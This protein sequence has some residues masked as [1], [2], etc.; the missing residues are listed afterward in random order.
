MQRYGI[1]INY[2]FCC[3]CHTCEVACQVEHGY[4]PKQW[5]IKVEQVGP[6]QIDGTKKVIYDCMPVMT[7]L[8]DMCKE[9]TEKGKLPTCAHH[10]QTGCMTYGPIEELVQKINGNYKWA[11]LSPYVE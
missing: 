11:L 5:G 3:N 4:A 8:C 7:N 9:R 2:D 6:F 10:C 1:L